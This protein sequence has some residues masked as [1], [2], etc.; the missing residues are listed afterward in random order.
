MFV[1]YGKL[2]ITTL[3]I[4]ILNMLDEHIILITRSINNNNILMRD[5]LLIVSNDWYVCIETVCDLQ[6]ILEKIIW[7]E[8]QI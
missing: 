3:F 1:D 4:K 8:K 5:V 2:I 7:K 6:L